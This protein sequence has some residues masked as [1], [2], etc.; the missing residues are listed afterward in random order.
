MLYVTIRL[1]KTKL[2]QKTNGEKMK[3]LLLVFLP[4]VLILFACSNPRDANKHN[5][6]K[7]LQDFYTDKSMDISLNYN[8]PL[9]LDTTRLSY[10]R[11]SKVLNELVTL[12]LLSSTDLFQKEKAHF[13]TTNS[14]QLKKVLWKKYSLTE[15]GKSVSSKFSS[16]TNF[17]YGKGY[18]VHE[19]LN[20]TEP[21]DMLGNRISKV[22]YNLSSVHIEDWAKESSVLK[23]FYHSV[24]EDIN[25]LSV[26]LKT[27]AVLVLTNNGWMHEKLLT[28]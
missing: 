5:F 15:K 12:G 6:K 9:E 24:L 10:K 13:L 26:P 4:L 17:C 27:Q 7:S 28:K 19:I 11:K 21:A 3:K 16:G 18:V 25:S 20:F 2:S 8:F 22:T 23:E 1:N 14:N